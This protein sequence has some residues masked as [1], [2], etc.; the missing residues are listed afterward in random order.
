[1]KIENENTFLAALNSG[2]NLFVGSG[3]STLAADQRGPTT[4]YWVPVMR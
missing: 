4:S 2:F 3:F 1:M